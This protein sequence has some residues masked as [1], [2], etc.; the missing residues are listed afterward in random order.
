MRF[1]PQ[2][3]SVSPLYFSPKIVIR[4]NM[5]GSMFTNNA[6]VYYKTHSL[7][8]ARTNTVKNSRAVARRT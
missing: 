2:P 5:I 7:E 4:S 3:V 1:G 6:S 8:T